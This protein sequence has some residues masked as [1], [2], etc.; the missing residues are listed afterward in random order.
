[1]K[2]IDLTKIEE[3][4]YQNIARVGI[5]MDP[6]LKEAISLAKEK[7]SN[8][9]AS[10]ILGD[11]LLN[12]QVAQDLQKPLCQDT[13]LAVFFV[14][15]G[16][17]ITFN[18]NLEETLNSAV[19][20]A[21]QD[22]YF[23]KSLVADPIFYR[24]NTGNNLPAIIHWKYTYGE[25]VKI[26]FSAKGGG[27]ENMSRLKMLKP[28]D[29]L[30]GVKDFILQT[31]IEGKGNPCPP[32]IVGVGLGGNFETCALL[33]KKA[34]FRDLNDSHPQTE[35]AKLESQLLAEI[36]A[37]NVGPQGLGGD[38]S[39]LAVKIEYL[40]CHIASLPVAVNIQCHSNRHFTLIY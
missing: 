35:W 31:V 5:V 17:E 22:F 13:G 29:G 30:Q 27:S 11:I 23:R 26:S 25:Q 14:E 1:M 32:I 33:A 8:P 36:N 3:D 4:I 28:A 37:S 18:G 9:L 7:E 40:P 6:D 24:K 20:R 15:V 16:S 12:G 21:Y 19:A 38:T 39:A 10:D 34:L 2:N